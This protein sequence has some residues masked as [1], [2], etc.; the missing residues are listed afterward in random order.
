MHEEKTIRKVRRGRLFPEIQWSPEQIAQ[1]QA[2]NEAI[3]QHCKA[4]FEQVKPKLIKTHYNWFMAIASNSDEYFIDKDEEVATQL[5]RHK[6]P[7][8]IPVLFKINETGAC[9]TI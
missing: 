7:D 4:I 2:E 6:Q 8:A 9:G 3:Y 5:L 1:S